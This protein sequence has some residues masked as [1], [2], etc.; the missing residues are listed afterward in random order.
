MAPS[1][2][3]IYQPQLL[4]PGGADTLN[5]V[6]LCLGPEPLQYRHDPYNAV[7]EVSCYPIERHAY[8]CD[9]S[10]APKEPVQHAVEGGIRG[11]LQR[12][13]KLPLQTTKTK[14]PSCLWMHALPFHPTHWVTQLTLHRFTWTLDGWPKIRLLRAYW[15][16]RETMLREKSCLECLSLKP[17]QASLLGRMVA[18]SDF[19]R[20]AVKW[21]RAKL[22]ARSSCTMTRARVRPFSLL[23]ELCN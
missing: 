17:K 18:L 22:L 16:C 1:L 2:P 4:C 12:Q 5:T 14:V 6:N 8:S 21:R 9:G 13:S 20:S 23:F 19:K 15:H 11:S 7:P 10:A 3:A